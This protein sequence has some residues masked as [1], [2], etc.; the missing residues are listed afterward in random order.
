[1]SDQGVYFDGCCRYILMDAGTSRAAKVFS[2]SQA[3][4]VLAVGSHIMTVC[5]SFSADSL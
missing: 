1:M 4:K 3:H 2:F 5:A